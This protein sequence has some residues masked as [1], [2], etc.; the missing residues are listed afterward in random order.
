[1][2]PPRKRDA[3]HPLPMLS[4]SP[5]LGSMG[6]P[7]GVAAHGGTH[8]RHPQPLRQRGTSPARPLLAARPLV[9]AL[10]QQAATRQRD[11]CVAVQKGGGQAPVHGLGF[12]HH[13]AGVD[14]CPQP[15][16]APSP[17][18]PTHPHTP[19]PTPTHLGGSP[20]LRRMKGMTHPAPA[21]PQ[22]PARAHAPAAHPPVVPWAAL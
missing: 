20:C 13:C 4:S 21:T 22:P 14:V 18:H 7:A 10:Q 3:H 12:A 16:L 8:A 15:S 1:M 11:K 9:T 6:G 5:P 19:T 17:P 2:I